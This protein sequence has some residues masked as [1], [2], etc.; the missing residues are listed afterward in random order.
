MKKKI[1]IIGAGGH[2]VSCLEIIEQNDDFNIIGIAGL[3][4]EI[5]KSIG[6]YKVKYSDDDLTKLKKK[7]DWAVVAI[8]Q[9]KDF[10]PRKKLFLKLKKIGFKIPKIISKNSYISDNC[11]IGEGSMIFNHVLI[12]SK[13]EIGKNCIINSKAL[14]EHNV[15]IGN[16]CH[17]STGAIVNGNVLIEDNCFIGSGSIIKQGIKIKKNSVIPMGKS[18]FK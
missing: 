1:I 3:K 10:K 16:N 12:N 5:G 13:A 4:K 17:I 14:I 18:V 2:S 9:I 15:K 8:G 7:C 11:K 6:N